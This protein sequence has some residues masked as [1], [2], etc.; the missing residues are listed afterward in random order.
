MEVRAP[1]NPGAR[2]GFIADIQELNLPINKPAAKVVI[3]AAPARL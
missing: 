2:V 1:V 3:N